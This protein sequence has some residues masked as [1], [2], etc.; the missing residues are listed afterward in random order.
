MAGPNGEVC[1]NCL[2]WEPATKGNWSGGMCRFK[3]PS[4]GIVAGFPDERQEYKLVWASTSREDWCHE[5]FKSAK[6]D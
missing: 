2:F 1:K 4:P 6:E 3:A 5:G